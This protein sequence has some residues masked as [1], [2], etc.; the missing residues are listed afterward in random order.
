MFMRVNSKCAHQVRPPG[1][2]PYCGDTQVCLGR[3]QYAR[4]RSFSRNEARIQS[5]YSFRD[6][7]KTVPYFRYTRATT[8]ARV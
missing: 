7:P 4:V 8:E 6:G 1:A 3:C 2:S 5:S